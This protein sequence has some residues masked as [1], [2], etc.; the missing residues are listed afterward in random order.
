MIPRATKLAGIGI[1]ALCAPSLTSAQAPDLERLRFE[2]MQPYEIQAELDRSMREFNASM[3][4]RVVSTPTMDPE[5]VAQLQITYEFLGDGISVLADGNAQRAVDEY[6]DPLLE[7]FEAM[8]EG[9]S[10]PVYVARSDKEGMYYVLTEAAQDRHVQAIGSYGAEV[11]YW[12]T[13]ALIRLNDRSAADAA[14][15]RAL[16]LSPANPLFLAARAGMH[17]QDREYEHAVAVYDEALEFARWLSPPSEQPLEARM[18]LLERAGALVEM[19]RLQEA[20]ADYESCLEMDKDDFEARVEL[21]YVQELI[22]RR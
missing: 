16:E 20:V 18:I 10:L 9:E 14:L 6:F 17:L 21:A 15:A 11:Y 13:L 7:V 19:G 12:K 8:V 4:R 1:V 22:A 2:R 5:R 3:R